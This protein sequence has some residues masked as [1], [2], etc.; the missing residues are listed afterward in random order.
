MDATLYS[1]NCPKCKVLETKLTQMG[2]KFDTV[3]DN[4]EVTEVGKSNGILSAPILKVGDKYFDFSNAIKYLKE[5]ANN[6]N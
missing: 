4:E 2:V 1:T 5:I 6:A 3:T